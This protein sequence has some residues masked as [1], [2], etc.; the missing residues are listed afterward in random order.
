MNRW[1]TIVPGG[2]DAAKEGGGIIDNSSFAPKISQNIW[3][4]KLMAQVEPSTYRLSSW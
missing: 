2:E 3:G 1:C 4:G